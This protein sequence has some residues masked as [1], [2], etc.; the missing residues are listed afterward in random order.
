MKRAFL[1]A[2]A[3]ASL[4]PLALAQGS[5]SGFITSTECVT[6][7]AGNMASGGFGTTGTWTG[8]LTVYGA[9]GQA[10]PVVLTSFTSNTSSSVGI[11]GYTLFKVCGN[12]VA[13]GA[14]FVQIS[15]SASGGS[16]NGVGV[17]TVAGLPAAPA[18][19]TVAVVKD[20]SSGTDCT[21]GG[22]ANYVLCRFVTG[23]GWGTF[24]GGSAAAGGATTQ[25]QYNNAGALGGIAQWTTNGTTTLTAGATG[26]LN[27]S[28]ASLTGGFQIPTGVGAAPTADGFAA[29]NTTTHLP[30][31]G[32]NGA[33]I[34]IPTT[35]TN[36]AHKWLNSYSQTTGGFTQ[37][38]P[39]SADLSDVANLV[40]NNQANTYSGGG[41]QDLNAMDLRLPNHA[42]DPATCSVGQIEFNT[43]GVATKVCTATNTWTALGAGGGTTTNALTMNNSNAGATSGSS[44]NGGAAV[45][46]S[47]NSVGAPSL[48]AAN[49]YSG[50]GLQDFNAMDLL[51]PVHAADPG[52]CTVGQIEF[53][54]TGVAMKVCTATNTWTA[55]A[56]GGTISSQVVGQFPLPGSAS[57]ITNTLTAGTNQGTY[58]VG[59]QN[60]TQGTA[61]SPSELQAGDCSAPGT[62]TGAGTTYTVVYTDAVGCTVVHD[63]AA[64]AGATI[65]LPTPTTLNNAHP[66]FVYRNDSGSS[67]TITPTTFTISLGNA[68]AGASVTVPSNVSCKVNLDP[69]NAS[70]WKADCHPN[71]TSGGGTTTNAVTFNNGGAGGASGSTFN[72]SAALTVSYNTIGAS[73]VNPPLDKS[74]TGLSNPTADATFTYPNTSTTGLTLSATA[75]ASSAGAGTPASQI[76]NVAAVAGGATTGSAT[77]AGVG[78][79]PNILAG[80]GGSGAGG[81]NAIGG[82][83]GTVDLTAGNGGASGGTAANSNGGNINLVPGVAGTGGSGTAGK[84]GVLS[85]NDGG[86]FA[87][88]YFLAQ[89]TANTTANAN[90]PANSILDQAPTSVTAYTITEPGAA[91]TNNNSAKLFTTAGVASFA[92]NQV[93]AFS[94]GSYTNATTTFSSV[95]GLSFSVDASSNYSMECHLYWQGSA[96]TAGIKAQITGP[97]SPTAVFIGLHQPLTASTYN[98]A[99]AAA[100]STSLGVTTAITPTTNFE[101]VLTMGLVNGVNAGTVQ[102]Q[103][104]AEGAGTLT[105]QN[106]SYCKLQ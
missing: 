39:S 35:L 86:G 106:G 18:T 54:S 66:I 17:Y 41:L 42:S 40:F 59:R 104:A 23:T 22:G 68:A 37:T 20:G 30:V 99:V 92:K 27:I 56:A 26:V 21:V 38:Q 81:T 78:S 76:F 50:G 75:P 32:N 36:S 9:V 96:T 57:S 63:R 91:P 43:V 5:N 33:T 100:F 97:A 48:S 102:I 15:T 87:G 94:T 44:F 1:F 69:T 101:A 16:G 29:F 53:N 3:I 2:L 12:T 73:V 46:I 28:G 25:V 77:T 31:F 52:T 47:A 24:S 45:T 65:T 7:P 8:T 82:A 60:T 14:A 72:G 79:S 70:T 62:V 71:A 95:T 58:Y 34:T 55:L 98:D 93:T 61:A 84:R 83:G 4:C 6:L 105:L 80:N 49:T 11:A 13:S 103:L 90:V 88:A 64:S 51:Q 10:A 85:V 74:A 19:G 67:D 89:G